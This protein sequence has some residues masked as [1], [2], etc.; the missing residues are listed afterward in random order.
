MSDLREQLVAD[1]EYFK[2]MLN[3]VPRSY[4]IDNVNNSVSETLS[5]RNT[6][7]QL[8]ISDAV[9]F[10][11]KHIIIGNLPFTLLLASRF[12]C[13]SLTIFAP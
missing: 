1:G 4:C 11:V 9:K 2:C 3:M 8:D 13:T 5:S 7:G 12:L 6:R 10:Q